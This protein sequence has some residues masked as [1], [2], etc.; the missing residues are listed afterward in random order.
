MPDSSTANPTTTGA[1]SGESELINNGDT[2]TAV[3]A[4]SSTSTA[5][6][7]GSE[8]HSNSNTFGR[9]TSNAASIR[10]PWGAV[11]D[12]PSLSVNTNVMATYASNPSPSSS[13]NSSSSNNLNLNVNGGGVSST[14]G[15][16]G[17]P[18]ELLAGLDKKKPGEYLMHLVVFN[19]VQI[20]SK[21]FEQIVNGDKKVSFLRVFITKK[22]DLIDY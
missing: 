10:L 4:S 19:F 8:T 12:K 11:R 6:K 1:G 7:I 15:L 14:G 3:Q 17:A 20:G 9:A 2:T 16:S 18:Q 5:T 22:R 13:S 21:K